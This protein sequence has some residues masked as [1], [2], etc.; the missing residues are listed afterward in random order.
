MIVVITVV[1]MTLMIYEHQ[2]RKIFTQYVI[3][4][5]ILNSIVHLDMHRR[6]LSDEVSFRAVLFV[7]PFISYCRKS[8]LV[9][10]V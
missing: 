2:K 9:A 7:I 1:D 3:L 6:I 10:L 5:M 4:S 8:Q